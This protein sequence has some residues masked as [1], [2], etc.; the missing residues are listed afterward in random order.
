MNI[1]LLHFLINFKICLWST[2]WSKNLWITCLSGCGPPNYI[3]EDLCFTAFSHITLSPLKKILSQVITYVWMLLVLNVFAFKAIKWTCFIEF[4]IGSNPWAS[5][6]T[7][8]FTSLY[9]K[10]VEFPHYYL[11]QQI[12]SPQTATKYIFNISGILFLLCFAWFHLF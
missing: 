5:G 2:K 10:N 12:Q 9:T 8:L 6:M 7:S 11:N 3:I 4:P 1:L